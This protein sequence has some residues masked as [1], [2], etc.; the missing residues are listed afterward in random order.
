[1]CIVKTS[2][3][4]YENAP[5][6]GSVLTVRYDG[7]WKKSQKLKYPVLVRFRSELE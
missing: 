5:A 1:M 7:V 4:D 6:E 3:F 2:G